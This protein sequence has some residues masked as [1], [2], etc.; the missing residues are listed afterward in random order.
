MQDTSIEVL[1]RYKGYLLWFY[2]LMGIIYQKRDGVFKFKCVT[3]KICKVDLIAVLI[4]S[5]MLFCA[6]CLI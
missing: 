1:E 3:L 2:I 6:V 5:N 4:Q